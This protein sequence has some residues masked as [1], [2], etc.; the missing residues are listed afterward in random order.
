MSVESPIFVRAE[1]DRPHR[2]GLAVGSGRDEHAHALSRTSIVAFDGVCGADT[3]RDVDTAAT[4]VDDPGVDFDDVAD[5]DGPFEMDPAGIDRYGGFLDPADHAA[6]CGLVDPAHHSAA[7]GDPAPVDVGGLRQEPELHSGSRSV[8]GIGLSTHG[9]ADPRSSGDPLHGAICEAL[10]SDRLRL[11]GG[12]RPRAPL[13]VDGH[14]DEKTVSCER[15]APDLGVCG[16]DRDDDVHARSAGVDDPG[17]G[18]HEVA[19][20]YWPAEVDVPDVGGDAVRP[21]P[22]CCTCETGTIDPLQDVAGLDEAIDT[23]LVGWGEEFQGLSG[24]PIFGLGRPMTWPTEQ[25]W[26]R[27]LQLGWFAGGQPYGVGHGVVHVGVKDARRD[28]GGVELV[29]GDHRGECLRGGQ[30]HRRCDLG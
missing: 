27:D 5:P 9:F 17:V 29:V 7:V 24:S 10:V 11:P 14:E 22:G 18:L 2:A 20:D 8:L 15:I 1:F 23:G 25:R 30:Q 4:C 3:R 19:G 6:V 28:V 13:F 12:D 16:A 21:A 26:S